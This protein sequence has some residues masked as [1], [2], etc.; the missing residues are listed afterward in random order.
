MRLLR[1]GAT[2]LALT[3]A[4]RALGF[5]RTVLAA[6]WLGA[7][8]SADAFFVAFRLFGLLR[9]ALGGGGLRAAFVPPFAR[10][11]G[12]RGAPAGRATFAADTIASLG[13]AAAVAAAIGALA[14]PWIVARWR[15]RASPAIPP[16]STRRSCSRG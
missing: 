9:A 5:A 16:A 11:P 10:R 2:V 8:P 1:A 14:M 4:G 3:L 13:A 12:P 7:G 6:A 15:R